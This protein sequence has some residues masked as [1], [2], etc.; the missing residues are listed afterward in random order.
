MA[1]V[2][3]SCAVQDTSEAR[4]LNGS[5]GAHHDVFP[6]GALIHAGEDWERRLNEELYDYDQL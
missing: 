4:A 3:I 1:R 6:A 5:L 2:F